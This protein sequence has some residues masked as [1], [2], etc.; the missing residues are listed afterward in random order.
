MEVGTYSVGLAS[1]CWL[2]FQTTPVWAL[3]RGSSEISTPNVIMIRLPTAPYTNLSTRYLLLW[4]QVNH[5]LT[6]PDRP[7]PSFSTT[8]NLCLAT[9]SRWQS[10]RW[11]SGSFRG[12]NLPGVKC[13]SRLSVWGA[14]EDGE[15]LVRATLSLLLFNSLINYLC[16]IFRI[17]FKVRE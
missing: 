11:P 2:R 8:L 1:L 12:V 14:R 16:Y 9:S 5:A 13:C 10:D 17:K 4:G 7:S 6:S 3:R 15:T